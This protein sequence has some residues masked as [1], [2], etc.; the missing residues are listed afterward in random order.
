MFVPVMSLGSIVTF[1]ER[2]AEGPREGRLSRA[3]V[4][5][6]KHVS[7]GEQ[8]DEDQLDHVVPTSNGRAQTSAQ[9]LGNL[10]CA[11]QRIVDG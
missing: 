2:I 10:P 5:F 3:R 11:G 4:V 9:A 8:R 7:V 1:F 6:E